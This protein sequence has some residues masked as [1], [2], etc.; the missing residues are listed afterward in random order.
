MQQS[1]LYHQIGNLVSRHLGLT[2]D[3]LDNSHLTIS[4]VLNET[5]STTM[6]RRYKRWVRTQV[7]GMITPQSRY[8]FPL[9]IYL[10]LFLLSL[11]NF[12]IERFAKAPTTT[13]FFPSIP[14]GHVRRQDIKHII[15]THHGD[16]KCDSLSMMEYSQGP[17]YSRT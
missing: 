12:G 9:V 10:S 4:R 11:S 7:K 17:S 3:G 14:V 13:T 8:Y 5:T 6:Q 1:T 2:P 15:N 16:N